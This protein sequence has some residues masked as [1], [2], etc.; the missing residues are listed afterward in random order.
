MVDTKDVLFNT[1]I[2]CVL[3]EKDEYIRDILKKKSV[4][5]GKEVKEGIEALGVEGYLDTLLD[6]LYRDKAE[7]FKAFSR[8]QATDECPYIRLLAH[9]VGSSLYFITRT[10]I[11]RQLNDKGYED[12]D[13]KKSAKTVGCEVAD[14][15]PKET[16]QDS[17]NQEQTNEE[18]SDDVVDSV[19]PVDVTTPA[20][21]G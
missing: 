17:Q 15:P 9:T 18:K 20:F 4:T 2:M 5:F 10:S 19:P 7:E 1:F 6:V 14:S 13:E 21:A 8:K 16:D 11:F 12:Y 3:N